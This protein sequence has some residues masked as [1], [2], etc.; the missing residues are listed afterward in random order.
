MVYRG[1]VPRTQIAKDAKEAINFAA[2]TWICWYLAFWI[3]YRP[4]CGGLA[5]L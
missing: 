4:S 5:T 2:T 1:T 3:L